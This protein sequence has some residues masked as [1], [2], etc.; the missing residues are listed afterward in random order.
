MINNTL[1]FKKLTEELFNSLEHDAEN[2]AGQAEGGQE[3]IS[4]AVKLPAR[5]NVLVK[6]NKR[7][8]ILG[9]AEKNSGKNKKSKM[10]NLLVN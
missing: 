10:K 1:F 3:I 4:R 6:F 8:K 2:L 7:R 5:Y 9:F